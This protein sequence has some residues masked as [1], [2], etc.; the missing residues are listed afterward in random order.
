MKK[1]LMIVA[2][3]TLGACA[4][5]P[6]LPSAVVMPTVS[7]DAL[8]QTTLA[9]DAAVFD[10]FNKCSAA[11]ELQKHEAHFSAD[12]E[13]YHDTGGV[14]WTRKEMIANTEKYVCG[15]FRR[16]LIPGTFKAYPIKDF[17]AIT[18]GTHRFCQFAS[19]KCEGEADFVMIWSN[20]GGRWLITRALS[21]G[22]RTKSST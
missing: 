10:A 9:L 6:H 5:G 22:H 3:T 7:T 1:L 16:E 17:G 15:N 8:T 18:Q 14:T 19:G 21:F 20:K 11:A 12:V 13:F 2:A 4:T